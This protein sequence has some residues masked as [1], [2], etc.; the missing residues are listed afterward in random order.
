[1]TILLSGCGAGRA[2]N[3][4]ETSCQSVEEFGIRIPIVVLFLSDQPPRMGRPGMRPIQI[5]VPDVRVPSFR[6]EAHR[7][8]LAVAISPHAQEDQAFIDSASEFTS[9][10]G[11][12]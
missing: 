3:F 5:W 9:A 12:E 11:D 6:S 8:S 7:Q 10:D 1:M 4:A 2:L